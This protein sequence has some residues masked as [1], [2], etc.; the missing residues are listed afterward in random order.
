[1]QAN[2]H[3]K[4]NGGMELIRGHFAAHSICLKQFSANSF[5]NNNVGKKNFERIINHQFHLDTGFITAFHK[6]QKCLNYF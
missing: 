5:K 4:K 3:R 2:S 1:M 6:E